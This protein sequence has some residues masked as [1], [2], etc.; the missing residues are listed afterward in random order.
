MLAA[1]EPANWIALAGILI[2][3]M[4]ALAGA[5]VSARTIELN[6][7]RT[8]ELNKEGQIS[9]RFTKA[10]DQLGNER[11]EIRLGGIYALERIAQD[12]ERDHWPIMEVLTA[13]MRAHPSDVDFDHATVKRM[14]SSDQPLR[15]PV[16]G[17][18]VQAVMRVIGRRELI[19]GE[20]DRLDLK[21]A[22]LRFLD[23]RDSHLERANLWQAHLERGT[24]IGAHLEG[25]DLMGAH[26]EGALLLGAHLGGAALNGAHL[27]GA[28][29]RNAHL[30]G[31]FFVNGAHLEGTDLRE[32]HLEGAF[33]DGAHLEGADLEGSVAD[34]QTRWPEGFDP[35][36]AGVTLL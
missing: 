7:A 12:F 31:A 25:A 10:I 13:F 5:W 3:P 2:A 32:A 19:D 29:L 18:D 1:W 23:M 36:K 21:G 17:A 15:N 4:A 14:E 8:I 33:L 11:L 24:L 35:A 27:E 6:T 26:L 20:R 30:E 9:D 34:S 22:D 16:R 28:V